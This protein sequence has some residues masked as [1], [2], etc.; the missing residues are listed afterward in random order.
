MTMYDI[1][2]K[3]RHGGELSEGEIRFFL[4]GYTKGEIPDYQAAALL[5]SIA[6]HGMTTEET[7]A[8]TLGIRDSGEVLRTS[9]IPGLRVDK[10]STGGV[11]DKTSLVVMPILRAAGLTVAKMSGRGLG[12]T[13]GTVDKLESIPGFRAELSEAEFVS[14]VRACG[15]AIVAQNQTLAPA[16]KKLYA[17]RDVTATV[18]SLPLI[19]SSIMGKKLAVDDDVIVLDVK[20]GNGAFMKT[21]EESR[22]L[23][24]Q[25]V[26]IGL[27]AGKK[28][29]ALVTDMSRPL[30]HA[31]GN[32]LEVKEAVETLRGRGPRD[33]VALST[34]LCAEIFA[35]ADLCDE[36]AGAARAEALLASG[37][38]LCAFERTVV[39]QGGDLQA[40][41]AQIDRNF[42]ASRYAF[43]AARDGYI[44]A[45]DTEAYGKAALALGAGRVT[46][47]DR[48]DPLSGLW[49][50]KKTGDYVKRGEP[51]VYLYTRDKTRVADAE[52][53]LRAAT[54]LGDEAP[55]LPPLIYEKVK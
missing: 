36:E 41:Y 43:C 15:M 52:A 17:L 23:A 5:T 19:A 51:L 35:L 7:V 44:T 53:I 32:L 21:P 3:K 33:L 49:L 1:L 25:M 22:A 27:A 45:V 13:G 20:T 2:Q 24:R 54:E 6:I 10:H 31:I 26:D 38:A 34:A 11:G 46:L 37:E 4:E 28:I 14:T 18:D 9:G 16:D 29:S 39:A 50:C 42:P 47:S 40:L 8:L 12:H 55:T 48:I 30:G